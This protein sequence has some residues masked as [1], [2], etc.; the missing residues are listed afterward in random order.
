MALA[1]LLAALLGSGAERDHRLG[2]AHIDGRAHVDSIRLLTGERNYLLQ[3]ELA[4]CFRLETVS[5]ACSSRVIRRHRSVTYLFG[6]RQQQDGKR[7][8]RASIEQQ[9]IIIV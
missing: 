9:R 8:G 4:A 2:P 1:K 7:L 3:A 5:F 6:L